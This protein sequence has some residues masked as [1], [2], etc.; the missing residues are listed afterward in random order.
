MTPE[1][2]DAIVGAANQAGIDPA[3]ALAVAQRESS[4]NPNARASRTMYGL[5][6]MSGANRAQYGGS[7]EDPK[8]QAQAGM[9][10][11]A[12]TRKD[13]ANRLGRNPTNQELYLGGYFGPAR[14][15]RMI[16]GQIAP[17]TDVRD[18]F[19]PQ[20]L[21]A[22]PNI[23]KAGTVGGLTSSVESDIGQREA[24]FS[25]KNPQ[26]SGRPSFAA[27]G[28]GANGE[29][30]AT[31]PQARALTYKST[32]ALPFAAAPIDFSSFGQTADD[33]EAAP[34]QQ[35]QA[36]PSPEQD[37]AAGLA[38]MAPAG[39]PA[40]MARE[41]MMMQAMGFGPGAVEGIAAEPGQ[42][43]QTAGPLP[44]RPL[45]AQL[46]TPQPVGAMPGAPTQ[47]ENPNGQA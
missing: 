4:G 34:E 37:E 9:R 42:Q 18:V 8:D 5:F 12:D 28:T 1:V 23:A 6:Q 17:S 41:H 33:V 35:E 32:S 40:S 44:Q 3:F 15:A 21:E 7:S 26:N 19:T 46:Q 27:F 22:N 10:F 30:P 36:A 39:T 14:A 13:L 2:Q 31:Q 20:E 45:G 25:G 11:Y 16:S 47:Q 43:P 29:P 24:A 38:G